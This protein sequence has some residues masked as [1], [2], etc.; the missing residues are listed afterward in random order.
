MVYTHRDISKIVNG[1]YAR[2]GEEAKIYFDNG[3]AIRVEKQKFWGLDKYPTLFRQTHAKKSFLDKIIF[4]SLFPDNSIE[5]LQFMITE[6]GYGVTIS[7]RLK[8]DDFHNVFVEHNR[9]YYVGNNA[10]PCYCTICS[11]QIE[12]GDDNGIYG[13]KN[14]EFINLGIQLVDHGP[15]NWAIVNNN[16]LYLEDVWF[17][18]YN[19]GKMIEQ[20]T[21]YELKDKG[22][23]AFEIY[24]DLPTIKSTDYSSIKVKD[25]SYSLTIKL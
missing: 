15:A 14:N 21:T 23:R 7:Y 6:D 2:E 8:L 5:P 16:P 25:Y 12:M 9:D 13:R 19:V 17:I 22:G 10:S 20:I 4:H 3:L 11:E 1:N 18:D 24:Q